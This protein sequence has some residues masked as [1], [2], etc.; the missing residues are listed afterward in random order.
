MA[1][2]RWQE[3]RPGKDQHPDICIEKGFAAG[4]RILDLGKQDPKDLLRQKEVLRQV[5]WRNVQNS[6]AATCQHQF[7]RVGVDGV[8]LDTRVVDR[9]KWN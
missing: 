8:C 1:T 4:G 7:T 9:T 6:I 5:K 2:G 3:A